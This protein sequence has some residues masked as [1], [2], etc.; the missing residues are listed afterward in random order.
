MTTKTHEVMTDERFARVAD[1]TTPA[2]AV[3]YFNAL[4][5]LVSPARA[6]DIRNFQI[7]L[8]ELQDRYGVRLATEESIE[9]VDTREEMPAGYPFVA[10][11]R[12]DGSLE[13][14]QWVQDCV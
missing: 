6:S 13:F 1:S 3:N 12:A 8:A 7:S 14:A 10:I 5:P 4:N 9:I 11:I 2:A